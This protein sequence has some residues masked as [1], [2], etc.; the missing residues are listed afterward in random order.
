MNG[1]STLSWIE[2]GRRFRQ[3][4]DAAVGGPERNMRI[5]SW[6]IS[7]GKHL[8]MSQPGGQSKVLNR[9]KLPKDATSV[10]SPGGMPMIASGAKQGKLVGKS[11]VLG[12]PC[13]IRQIGQMKLHTWKGLA[14]KMQAGPAQGPGMSMEATRLQAPAYLAQSLFKIPTGYTIQD[15][16]PSAARMSGP[17]GAGRPP[18]PGPR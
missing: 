5:Q 15:F 16:D 6:A 7:D 12:R 13:E 3:D 11:T 4:L 8:Y 10:G 17:P 1:T 18:Q 14:L 9:M 2:D